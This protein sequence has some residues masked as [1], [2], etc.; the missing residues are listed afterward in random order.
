VSRRTVTILVSVLGALLLILLLYFMGN[1]KKNYL[2]IETYRSTSEQP[3]G[4][5]FIKRLLEGSADN[6]HFINAP[7][8]SFSQIVSSEKFDSKLPASY[9]FIGY[10]LMQSENDKTA[11]LDFISKGNDAFISTMALPEFMDDLYDRECGSVM[12]FDD[13]P[14]KTATM[15]FY[16][17]TL[18]DKY[19]YNYSY[20][21][22][23][24][25][26]E[27]NWRSFDATL[28]CD[29]TKNL[30]P[31]GYINENNVNFLKIKY[32]DGWVYLHSNPIVF[33][34][35][36][37]IKSQKAEY[38]SAVFSHLRG[39]QIIWDEFGKLPFPAEG[40]NNPLYFIMAQPSL[41]YAW[42]MIV[43]A[44]LLYIAFAVK[45]TQRI[46]PVLEQ[47]TNTSLEFVK[48]VSALHF[49]NKNHLD[50]ARKKWKYFQYFVRSK[51]GIHIHGFSDEIIERIA[52]KSK[53]PVGDVKAVFNL[54]KL[55][56]G[57]GENI[58]ATRLA[59]FY[60]AIENFY[61]HCK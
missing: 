23:T 55:V 5:A 13:Q 43:A 52:E 24:T 56:E 9:I 49:Q 33:T 45:R 7:D 39:K 10:A 41:K 35:Y 46:I 60:Y 3:Y 17:P 20:R 11:L 6:E 34:N 29:S 42:W 14:L 16:H 37:L 22:G 2:W 27:Y 36:F 51:Y 31:L 54:H 19:G 4:T 8:K 1:R 47:K 25:D 57:S 32:G 44:V 40:S 53:V 59:N 58:E 28:F 61:K 21:F 26:M 15:N 12:V 30:T 50:I 18:H 38:A 48:M